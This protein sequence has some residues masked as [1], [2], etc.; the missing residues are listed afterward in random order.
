MLSLMIT[1]QQLIRSRRRAWRQAR[2]PAATVRLVSNY[3]P[4]QA[5][6]D[7]VPPVSEPAQGTI[8]YYIRCLG[9]PWG[10]AQLYLDAGL[11][12]LEGAANILLSSSS[13]TLSS[14]RIPHQPLGESS[15]EAWKSDRNAAAK[16]FERA[17]A[18]HP[19]LDV[20]LLPPEADPYGP[21]QRTQVELEMPS[22]DL[23][24]EP[25]APASVYSVSSHQ[26]DAITSVVQKRRR[27][28]TLAFMEEPKV[29]DVDNT[30][31]LSIPG[32]TLPEQN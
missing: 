18:L 11:L 26:G 12:H 24:N 1:V 28:E 20:P 9:G 19:D 3:V 6:F 21:H 31:C 8:G 10:L 25:S 4:I 5:S 32:L 17:R 7:L 2:A 13:S 27:S 23:K 15:T 16:Y 29:D 14:I 30:H 22:L